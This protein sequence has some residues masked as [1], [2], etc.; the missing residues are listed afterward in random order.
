MNSTPFTINPEDPRAP[1]QE[2]WDRLPP[3]ERARIVASLPSE[4]PTSR[5]TPPEGG[6]HFEA[7]VRAQDVLGGFFSRIGRKVFI[8]CELPVYYPEEPMF[9][10][11]LIAV[12][13]VEPHVRRHWTVSHEK[14]GVDLALEVYVAGDWRK[15]VERNVE[16][17]ARLGL[18]EYFVFDRTRLK[19]M[20]WRLAEGRLTYQPILAQQG[21]YPSKVLGLELQVEGDRL[22]FY[23]GGAVLPESQEMVATLR[24]MLEESE[25]HRTA[26]LQARTEVE[27][28]LDQETR[29]REEAERQ[30][31]QARA[32][33]ERLRGQR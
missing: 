33:L 29:L 14:K 31:D 27:Q 22:R 26:E 8:G 10:P 7:K 12:L 2:L 3:E 24:R 19:L 18:R 23:Y 28:R 11:D 21:F 9:A 13:D 25:A 20:G 30:L 16:R 4:F 32:E 1:S 17:Y 6:Y 15:D 5:A